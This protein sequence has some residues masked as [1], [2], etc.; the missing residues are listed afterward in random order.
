MEE[1]Q[2]M[3]LKLLFPTWSLQIILTIDNLKNT[4]NGGGKSDDV[5]CFP[6][7]HYSSVYQGR[8]TAWPCLKEIIIFILRMQ[9]VPYMCVLLCNDISCVV[10]ARTAPRLRW[11][12][13]A[14][15]RVPWGW[16]N[17]PLRTDWSCVSSSSRNSALERLWVTLKTSHQCCHLTIMNHIF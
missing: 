15:T 10:Q 9:N 13:W 4:G 16:S 12:T 8:P 6:H 11:R 3:R 5:T 7:E 1:S 17:R 2:I 14:L